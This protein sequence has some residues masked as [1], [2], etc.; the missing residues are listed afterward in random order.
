MKIKYIHYLEVMI[1]TITRTSNETPSAIFF[2]SHLGAP[3]FISC[4]HQVMVF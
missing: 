4:I 1:G 3:L 2:R